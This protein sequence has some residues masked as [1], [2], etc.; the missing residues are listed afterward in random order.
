[1]LQVLTT[2]IQLRLTVSQLSESIFPHPTMCEA[3]MEALHDVHGMSIHK[4]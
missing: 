1:M 4:L 2:A 3:V